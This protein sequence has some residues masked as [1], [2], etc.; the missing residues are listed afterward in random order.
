MQ[1]VLV[2]LARADGL[3]L[4][5]RVAG[6]ADVPIVALVDPER[7]SQA[8]DALRQGAHD[9]VPKDG[10][11]GR[12]LVRMIERAIERHGMLRE[13]HQSQEREHFLATHDG[14][15]GLANRFQLEEMLRH[16][17]ASASRAGKSVA[18]LF[19]DLDRFK[20]INETLGHARGDELLTIAA[21]R[22]QESTRKSDLLARLGGDEFVVALSG[23]NRA[24][25]PAL[26]AQK[27]LDTLAWPF[28][29]GESEYH[30]TA[31]IGIA[32]FPRDGVDPEA[33]MRAADTAMYDA[34]RKGPNR[35]HFFSEEM[36]QMV[37]ERLAL[38]NGLFAAL[39]RREFV[40]RYQPQVD[41]S[42]GELIGLEAQLCW[43]RPGHG[44]VSADRFLPVAEETGAVHRI[45]QWAL[46][47]AC[48]DVV[49]FN[50]DRSRPLRAAV[51]VSSRELDQERFADDVVRIL[52]ETGLEPRLLDLEITEGSVLGRQELLMST[53]QVLRRIGVRV[54]VD[55]F[56]RG[57]C[58]LIE[59]RRTPLDGF[60]I[61]SAF[62]AGIPSDAT[63][64]TISKA[65]IRMARGLGLQSCAIGVET[66][67]QARFLFAHGCHRMQGGLFGKSVEADELASL[68]ASDDPPWAIDP[69]E[70]S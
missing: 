4:I 26:V 39:S 47:R 27:L 44:L 62:V 59:L 17:M 8:K 1:A 52:H 24:H 30:V 55:D 42:A 18:I 64:A 40:L 14:L 22:L 29:L 45:G 60:K 36:N 61:D 53:I 7:D 51:N 57:H 9:T 46:R 10:E 67:E 33:L 69:E 68:L 41:V 58:P 54:S 23:V 48:E 56:G 66:R 12:L 25:I 21:S 3:D 13:L 32:V 43:R 5:R 70:L 35:Y 16:S 31:S 37:A 20:N 49:G 19:L 15:T 65:L 28:R 6:V 50:R 63:N 11:D 38:E 34:K 2:D